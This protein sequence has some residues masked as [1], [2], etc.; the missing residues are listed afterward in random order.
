MLVGAPHPRRRTPSRTRIRP[1]QRKP[2]GD[3]H[4]SD[5]E[6]GGSVDDTASR[7]SDIDEDDKVHAH[8]A[9]GGTVTPAVRDTDKATDSRSDAEGAVRLGDVDM[10]ETAPAPAATAIAAAVDMAASAAT[11]GADMTIDTAVGVAASVASAGDANVAVGTATG[12][13][14]PAVTAGDAERGQ[15]STASTAD[16]C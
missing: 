9:P 2:A 12:A 3:S 8:A 7:F 14:V 5:T 1:P 16:D 6:D 4:F 11:D 10:G 13:T 15:P